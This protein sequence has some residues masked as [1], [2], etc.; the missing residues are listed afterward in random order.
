MVVYDDEHVAENTNYRKIVK[1]KL[2]AVVQC[3]QIGASMYVCQGG[4]LEWREYM[5]S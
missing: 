3:K 4:K 2:Y 1:N 5:Q